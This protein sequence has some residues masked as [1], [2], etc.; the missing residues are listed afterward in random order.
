MISHSG[1]EQTIATA[2][3]HLA[4]LFSSLTVSNVATFRWCKFERV[5][6]A[7]PPP[8][9]SATAP[10][11][12]SWHPSHRA[13]DV[14]LA[15]SQP[16]PPGAYGQTYG[17]TYG[18]PP[19][20]SSGVYGRT[21][22]SD[23]WMLSSG[24]IVPYAGR[25][26]RATRYMFDGAR[27]NA[28]A[29]HAGVAQR[30]MQSVYEDKETKPEEPRPWRTADSDHHFYLQQPSMT[31]SHSYES[32]K[33]NRMSSSPLQH[34]LSAAECN[35]RQSH[36]L[37][38]SG[39]I[40]NMRAKL[41]LQN[42]E[43]LNRSTNAAQTHTEDSQDVLKRCTSNG[44]QT[45]TQANHNMLHKADLDAWQ[46]WALDGEMCLCYAIVVHACAMCYVVMYKYA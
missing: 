15:S 9:S 14:S 23:E 7:A 16:R 39:F 35:Q 3:I 19:P 34:S 46:P 10:K 38:D 31:Y 8:H 17:Q 27:T 20:L 43:F 11:H 33:N 24:P 44:T 41:H 40:Q 2:G 25:H 22:D 26:E 12:D 13:A 28:H 1:S 21:F 36:E 32:E 42:K 4:D 6:S 45:Q 30:H 29:K 5:P 37:L 18:V